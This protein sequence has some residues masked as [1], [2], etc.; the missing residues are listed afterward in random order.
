MMLPS[1]FQ[2]PVVL[3]WCSSLH[4][5]QRGLAGLPC[6]PWGG[7]AVL[8][9]P[10]ALDSWTRKHCKS[11]PLSTTSPPRSLHPP[12]TTEAPLTATWLLCESKTSWPRGG[13]F[14][15]QKRRPGMARWN[16][17]TGVSVLYLFTLNIIILQMH[18]V[19]D[20]MHINMCDNIYIYCS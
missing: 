3:S 12:V 2:T 16:P 17:E 19:Q 11:S 8:P 5:A 10:R 13:F 6:P 20:S 7:I 18:R 15:S 9:P 1:C 4:R 14:R